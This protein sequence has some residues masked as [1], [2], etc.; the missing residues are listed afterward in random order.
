MRAAKSRK[1]RGDRNA[2][3][4]TLRSAKLNLDRLVARA[5]RGELVYIVHG[6]RRFLLQRVLEIEP[7]PMRPPGYFA[8]CYSAEEIALENRFAK[9]S[10][11]RAPDDLE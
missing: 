4:F 8:D 5:E 2:A 10:V 6:R 11:V 9:T 1:A 3:S 7:I